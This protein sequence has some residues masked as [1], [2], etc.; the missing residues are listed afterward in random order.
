MRAWLPA[1]VALAL[2][3]CATTTPVESVPMPRTYAHGIGGSTFL[4]GGSFALGGSPDGNS[5]IL[6]GSEG[7]VLVDSGRHAAHVTAIEQGLS[8]LGA[9]LVAEIGRAHV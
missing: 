8:G 4:V 3:G 6:L 2:A 7:A 1:L 5:V 9:P